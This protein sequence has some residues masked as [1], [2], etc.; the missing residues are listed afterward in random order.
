M[1]PLRSDSSTSR[2]PKGGKYFG[3]VAGAVHLDQLAQLVICPLCGR[4]IPKSARYCDRC[5]KGGRA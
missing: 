1:P 5:T 4:S 3:S 2:R